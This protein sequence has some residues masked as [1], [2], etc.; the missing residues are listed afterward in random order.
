MRDRADGG[1]IQQAIGDE[2]LVDVDADHLAEHD[3]ALGRNAVD[4]EWI[5][6]R[7]TI[8][9]SVISSMDTYDG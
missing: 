9:S 2:V 8:D 1:R 3:V 5:G 7:A 6:D 4:V